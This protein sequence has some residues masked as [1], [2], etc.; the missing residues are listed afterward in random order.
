[1]LKQFS[2]RNYFDDIT[3]DSYDKQLV[4]TGNIIHRERTSFLKELTPVFN[5]YYT[6]ISDS[7]EDV[8]L[9]FKSQITNSDYSK[10]LD[11]YWRETKDENP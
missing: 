7:M 11:R 5:K 9:N 6:E 8:N 1:M 2:D 10:I 3:L 4:E